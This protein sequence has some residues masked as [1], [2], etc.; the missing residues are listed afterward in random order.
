MRTPKPQHAHVSSSLVVFH[1]IGGE[2]LDLNSAVLLTKQQLQ[3]GLPIPVEFSSVTNVEAAAPTPSPSTSDAAETTK[4]KEKVEEGTVTTL[5]HDPDSP[6]TAT[7]DL[8]EN[9]NEKKSADSDSTTPSS[10][11]S[12]TEPDTAN[13]PT[14]PP[15]P[16][17]KAKSKKETA[18]VT[19][20]LT[21]QQVRIQT[22]PDICRFLPSSAYL[23]MCLQAAVMIQGFADPELLASLDKQNRKTLEDVRQQL[24]DQQ[25]QK[26]AAATSSSVEDIIIA[27]RQAMVQHL[28]STSHIQIHRSS[29]LT[30]CS[31]GKL[32]ALLRCMKI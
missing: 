31:S 15:P 17:P 30:L 22:C 2:V 10:S 25:L 16:P 19:I 8:K 32:T 5:Y 7:T 12:T 23:T 28:P 11:L 27:N 4:G 18:K 3:E 29:F 1:Y 13:I 21:T 20:T 9:N 24:L 6:F 26:Q 14:P